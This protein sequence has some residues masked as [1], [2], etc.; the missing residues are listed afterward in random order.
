MSASTACQ[1]PIDAGSAGPL[2]KKHMRRP[3]T[4]LFWLRWAFLTA[5]VVIFLGHACVSLADRHAHL[6]YLAGTEGHIPDDAQHEMHPASCEQAAAQSRG[7]LPMPVFEA[8]AA[9]VDSTPIIQALLPNWTP[10]VDLNH[11]PIFLPHTSFL[12]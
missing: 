1:Q 5:S 10:I 7:S 6:L 3:Y 12:I 2:S 11:A 8:G 4:Y 9:S